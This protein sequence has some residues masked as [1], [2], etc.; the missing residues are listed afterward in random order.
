MLGDSTK[1]ALLTLMAAAGFVWLTACAN[2]ANLLLAQ[3]TTRRREFAVR[4]ALGAS[5]WRLMR[6]RWVSMSR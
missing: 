1:P 5:R 2:V 6:A 4:A 3:A